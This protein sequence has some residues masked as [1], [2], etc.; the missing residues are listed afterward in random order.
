[1]TIPDPK[2]EKI[3][4]ELMRRIKLVYPRHFLQRGFFA[5][6]NTVWPAIYVV[7]DIEATTSDRLKRKGMYDRRASVMI[8]L[9]FKGPSDL[10]QAMG[11][12]NVEKNKLCYAIELD[13][14]FAGMCTHY[15]EVE[16]DKVFYKSNG[17]QIAVEYVFEYSEHSPWQVTNARRM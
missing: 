12:A 13:D 9:F 15:G 10:Q 7:E 4:D 6:E 5:D 14:D 2:I 3:I 8:S 17:I 11:T 1:M 16:F